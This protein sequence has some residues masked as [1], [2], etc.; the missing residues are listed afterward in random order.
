M[1]S[2]FPP[3]ASPNFLRLWLTTYTLLHHAF[4]PVYGGAAY[5]THPQ[6][7]A[8]TMVHNPT[9]SSAPALYK[10]GEPVPVPAATMREGSPPPVPPHPSA[11]LGAGSDHGSTQPSPVQV[12][13]P[14]IDGLIGSVPK[15]VNQETTMLPVDVS[16][17]E[18]HTRRRC[19]SPSL[20]HCRH[21]CQCTCHHVVISNVA[22]TD[23][24]LLDI[25]PVYPVPCARRPHATRASPKARRTQP[26]RPQARPEPA[27]AAAGAKARGVAETVG[28]A[29]RR[30]HHSRARVPRS[31]D[32]SRGLALVRATAT[33]SAG[34]GTGPAPAPAI[35]AAAGTA[36]HAPGRARDRAAGHAAGRRSP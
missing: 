26:P 11:P 29:A 34:A 4:A 15:V 10:D 13:A 36:D 35:A 24:P 25:L 6:R 32:R 21:H 28:A 20:C 1:E 31:L 30:P 16:V 3:D 12:A 19:L 14:G 23:P 17:S 22:Y 8:A 9:I 18:A 2:P 7:D 5:R 33:G 27:R